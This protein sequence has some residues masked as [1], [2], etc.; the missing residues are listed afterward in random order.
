M[1]KTQKKDF[2]IANGKRFKKFIIKS[3]IDKIVD[4]LAEQINRDYA[5][6]KVLFLVVLKGSIFFSSDLLRKIKLDCEIETVRASSYGN[7][8]K[9]DKLRLCI[10]NIEI[11]NKHVIVIEDIVDTGNTLSKLLNKLRNENPASLE[12]ISFLS[13]PENRKINVKVKYIGIQ[14]PP[15]F[16]IGYGLDYAEQGRHLPDIY[17]LDN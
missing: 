12:A 9:N 17:I 8:M 10:E 4:D 11:K 16:A 14:I 6:K 1:A 2:F 7:K 13:K 3:D 15:L 5:G